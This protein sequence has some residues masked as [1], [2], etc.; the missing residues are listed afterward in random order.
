[1]YL[2]VLLEL[3][4]L[5][6]SHARDDEVVDVHLNNVL[7]VI[8]A[9]AVDGMLVLALAEPSLAQG[10]NHVLIPCSQSLMT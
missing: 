5:A 8:G 2:H 4:G 10:T 1:L 7:A 6:Q 3:L 9:L